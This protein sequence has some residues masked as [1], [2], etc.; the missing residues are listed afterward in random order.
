MSVSDH[1][2]PAGRR[3]AGRP[4]SRPGDAGILDRLP[5]SDF[6]GALWN[7]P[8]DQRLAVYLADVAGCP[9]REIAEIM[10]TPV[11]AVSMLLHRARRR[12]RDMLTA[13]AVRRGLAAA[14]R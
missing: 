2:L 6:L 13:S 1:P 11:S 9:Y 14:P 10:G 8:D 5:D 4:S 3:E 12:L 7:L